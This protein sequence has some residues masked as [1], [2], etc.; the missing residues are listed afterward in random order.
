MKVLTL[1]CSFAAFGSATPAPSQWHDKRAAAAAT[2][3]AAHAIDQPVCIL[4]P[5]SLMLLLTVCRLIIS[6]S[7]IAM[8][9]T[10]QTRSSN[11]TFLI[12]LTISLEDQCSYTL[13]ERQAGRVDSQTC[14][15]AVGAYSTL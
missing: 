12:R 6:R 5:A 7:L 15:L 4:D 9:L 14:K 3:Y 1:L 2:A 10:Q 11:G 13:V 8:F